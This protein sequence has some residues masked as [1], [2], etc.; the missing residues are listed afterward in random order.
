ME[1]DSL[2]AQI[3]AASLDVRYVAIYRANALSMFQRPGVIGADTNET[4]RYEELFVNPALL[5]LTTQR[6]NLDCGGLRYLLVRY[7]NFFQL[8]HP[9]QEGHVS[10]CIGNAEHADPLLVVTAVRSLLQHSNLLDL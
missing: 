7:G 8:V 4:D 10:V 5:K 3:F 6:G 9:I 2:V 1:P